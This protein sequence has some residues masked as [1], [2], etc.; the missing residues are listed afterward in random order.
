MS[1][2][3]IRLS[4]LEDFHVRIAM[5][6]AALSYEVKVKDIK[7]RDRHEN[8]VMARMTAYWMLCRKSGMSTT[9]IGFALG[10]D[11]GAVISGRRK[12]QGIVDTGCNDRKFLTKIEDAYRL[13]KEFAH[14]HNVEK[15]RRMMGELEDAL[16][17]V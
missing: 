14:K 1:K 17:V 8:L 2:S 16:R 3:R 7:S 4:D 13:Y 10:R 9:R 5:N 6:A 12:I 15:T 11:H